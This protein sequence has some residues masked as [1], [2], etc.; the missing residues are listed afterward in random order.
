MRQCL[1]LLLLIALS[2]GFPAVAQPVTAGTPCDSAVVGG[3]DGCCGFKAGAADCSIVCPAPGIAV[4]HGARK[5]LLPE[6]ASAS[7]AVR[8]SPFVRPLARGPD[9]APPK[10][11]VV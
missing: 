4:V 11:A 10:S 2:A 1:A 9:T 8:A 3:A 6:V 7:P 5:D